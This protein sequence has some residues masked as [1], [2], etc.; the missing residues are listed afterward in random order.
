MVPFSLFFPANSPPFSPQPLLEQAPVSA[1]ELIPI[2]MAAI[3]RSDLP[4]WITNMSFITNFRLSN[5]YSEEI[6]FSISSFQA[7]IEFIET[8]LGSPS[9]V[10]S[11]QDDDDDDAL[12]RTFFSLFVSQRFV[13]PPACQRERK[14]S[15]SSI[16]KRTD[17]VLQAGKDTALTPKKLFEEV[18]KGDAQA[19]VALLS[20]SAEK[21]DIES[22]MCH[23]L[24]DCSKCLAV[25]WI[26]FSFSFS[27]FF[28][29]HV[30]VV[31]PPQVTELQ[32][33]QSCG[34]CIDILSRRGRLHRVASRGAVWKS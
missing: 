13:N 30:D 2:L 29:S 15:F 16:K 7:A 5:A 3:I 14:F 1:D 23:P 12:V 17:S 31:F 10:I 19:V 21:V 20:N 25:S 27:F 18:V 4:N 33:Q 32:V 28:L 9:A 22:L 11:P 6:R 34:K 24:C 8:E 26:F